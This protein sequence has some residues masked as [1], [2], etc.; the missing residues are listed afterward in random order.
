MSDNY[1]ARLNFIEI[2]EEVYRELNFC[3]PPMTHDHASSLVMELNVDGINY[4][5][6]HNPNV[7]F[8]CCLL[9]TRLE[10]VT[11]F[12]VEEVLLYLLSQNFDLSRQY[13]GCFA[14]NIEDN[15]ILFN[16][17]LPIKDLRGH[18]LLQA[19][20][21]NAAAAKNWLTILTGLGVGSGPNPSDLSSAL[22]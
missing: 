10:K 8:S 18:D 22:A 3:P 17:S 14:A 6:V 20:R 9:E 7:N 13:R 2:V 16:F 15:T 4:E 11:A 19:M 12:Q 21:E 1:Q 5:V